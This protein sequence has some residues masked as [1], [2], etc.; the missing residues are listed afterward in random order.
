MPIADCVPCVS[1][2]ECQDGSACTEDACE[3]GTC[4]HL[5]ARDCIPC[6]TTADCRDD[7]ECTRESCVEGVCRTLHLFDCRQPAEI[8][9]DCVD[10]DGD[11]RTDF[12]DPACCARVLAT[13][14]FHGRIVPRATASRLRLQAELGPSP[15]T[16]P[17]GLTQD[18]FLQL[19]DEAARGDLL[20]ARVPA[21]AFVGRRRAFRFRDRKRTVASARGLQDMSVRI[22]RRGQV[23]LKTRGA[24]VAMVDARQGRVRVTVAMYGTG[25]AENACWSSTV[26]FRAN[27]AGKL[28]TP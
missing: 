6:A 16:A 7:D 12:E 26:P 10:N 9:G 4:T 19:R 3:G 8:C 21:A 15:V 23:R 20:C 18:V 11:G 5:L 1:A 25:G 27:R 24:R 28:V 14:A 13:D 22:G 17:D 2:A